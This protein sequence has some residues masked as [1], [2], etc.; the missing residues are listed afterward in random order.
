LSHCPIERFQ[1]AEKD[2]WAELLWADPT[3]PQR[4][5][6]DLPLSRIFRGKGLVLA[7][8]GWGAHDRIPEQG[9][10]WLAFTN[11]DYFGDHDHL[12]VNA[13]QIYRRGELAID[14]G[15][16]D[17]DW[18]ASDDPAK[19]ARSQ[20]FN[21][22][23]RTIAHNTLLVHDPKEAFGRGLLNDGGQRHLL[24]KGLRRNVPED[25]AQ[26]TFPSDYGPG[27]SDWATNPGRWERGDITAYNATPDFVHVRGDGT[28]AYS[29]Q[30]VS[31]FVRDLV[32][33][34]PRLVVVFDRV[35]STNPS[36][37]KTWLLHAVDEPRLAPDGAWFEVT[38]GNGRLFGVP[39]LPDTPRLQKVG[40][41]GNEFTVAGVA[42]KAGLQSE[43]NPSA[44]HYGETPG[45]WRIE[46]KPATAQAEDYF[47]NVMLLTDRTSDERPQIDRLANDASALTFRARDRDGTSVSVWF[48]KG[49]KSAVSMKIERSGGV[50]FDGVLPD[51][52]ILEDGR[53]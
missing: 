22:Y 26:G 14:S 42:F 13:F 6:D 40:G 19:I 51:Q 30:K 37:E 53:P 15:R 46:E 16:Y 47:A 31:A 24:W 39:I 20:F 41:P 33:V 3:I 1:L 9:S 11:G 43:L 32:F 12:D 50:V 36:F 25:Y 28:R 7:H 29:A 45:A 17:D 2:R 5:L 27:T 10:T 34:R 23:Q 8:T 52:V 44:L 48:A 38:E 49:A 35:V 18:D 4:P 21:Y